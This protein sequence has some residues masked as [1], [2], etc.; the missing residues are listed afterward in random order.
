VMKKQ[1]LYIKLNVFDGVCVFVLVFVFMF[2]FVFVFVFVFY[3]T[4][5]GYTV[6]DQGLREIFGL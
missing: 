1:F 4:T 3:W 2:V 6:L 5:H